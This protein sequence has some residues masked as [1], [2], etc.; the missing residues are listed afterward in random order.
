MVRLRSDLGPIKI[1]IMIGSS[2]LSL[3]IADK[4]NIEDL[5]CN[6]KTFA[7]VYDILLDFWEIFGPV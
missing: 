2:D 6:Q 1:V 7:L 3:V 4:H 5:T